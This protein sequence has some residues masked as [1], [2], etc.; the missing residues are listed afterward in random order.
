V[1]QIVSVVASTHNPRIFWNRDQATPA[2]MDE[3]YATFGEVRDLLAATKPDVLVVVAN[4]HLDNFFFDNLPTFS[5]GTGPSAE[6]P[7]WYESDIMSLPHYKFDIHQPFAEYLLRDGV[8]TGIQFS[9]ARELHLDHAFT[10]PLSFL[11]PGADLP[12][13]PI[14]TNAFGYPIANNRRWYELGHF[15]KRAVEAWPGNERVALLCSFNLTVEVGGPKMGNIDLVFARYLLELMSAGK[16]DEILEKLTVERLIEAGN[17][18]VEFLN[19]VTALGVVEDQLPT[20]IRHKPV[21]GVGTC[22]IAF[23]NL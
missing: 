9:Q 7:F 2:D 21:K 17:S 19:Y 12:V 18:T 4:D 14:V 22:P 3:L 1:A 5:V 13:V 10:V 16:R 6:G 15:L 11:R 8:E 20:F 23:W